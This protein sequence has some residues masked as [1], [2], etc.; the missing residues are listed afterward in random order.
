MTELASGAVYTAPETPPCWAAS[1]T[2]ITGSQHNESGFPRPTG[3][4]MMPAWPAAALEVVGELD[5]VLLDH[6]SPSNGHQGRC[7]SGRPARLQS[8]VRGQSP[9]A[10]VSR[11]GAAPELR[12]ARRP[13]CRSAA[14]RG[15]GC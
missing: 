4:V 9:R 2:S 14:A 8:P 11:S 3:H 7:G 15:R 13:W 6:L 1:S 12:G 10:N 5:F